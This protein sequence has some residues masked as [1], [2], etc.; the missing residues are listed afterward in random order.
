[1]ASKL[2]GGSPRAS[3]TRRS[4]LAMG[5]TGLLAGGAAVAITDVTSKTPADAATTSTTT[6]WV[7]VTSYG[8]DPTGA[9]DST[10]AFQSAIDS[11]TATTPSNSAGC[12][13]VYI[14]AGNYKIS[15]TVNCPTV[16][17]YFVG[18]G[19]WATTVLFYGSGDCFRIYDKS[20][21]GSRT[22]FGG[23]FVGI[24]IDG[25]NATGAAT[26]LHVG[27][28]LQYELDLTVQ[29]F[30]QAG[31]IGV[32]LDNNYYWT[33]QL[34]G[35]IYAQ[36]CAS[37][38]V[39]DWTSG[40]ATTSSGSFER[41]D[42]D[43]YINQDGGG[44]D[45]VV[46]RN[47]AFVTNGSLKIR[48]NFGYSSSTVTS[49]ALRL[50]GSQSVNGYPSASGIVASML[51]IGAECA[52]KA[53]TYVPQTIVFGASSNQIN[54][55]YGALNFGAAGTTFAASNNNKNIIN[56]VGQSNGDSTLPG[57]TSWVTYS[58]GFPTGITG[59]VSFRF[60]P[61]GNEVMVSW[62]LA[63]AS[64][65]KMA[66]NTTIVTAASMYSA[67]DNKLLPGNATGAGLSGNGYAAASMSPGGIFKYL[68]P[69]YT[70]TGGSSWW[71]GQ[72][73]YTLSVG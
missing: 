54:G 30:S 34:F 65:T 55:C 51:D 67:N 73:V 22:K 39:F 2:H 17:V 45:G 64:G 40:T 32:H 59:N 31:S 43:I 29:S 18:D 25:T 49:A 3:S 62:A 47:G 52:T 68:G 66:S 38:V 70:S 53:G 14:P 71:F 42:L 57:Q 12:G 10:S 69:A 28:L 16:P 35:R 6:D 27:D 13:V 58:S 50:T 33:E 36:K 48:G 61:T 24:T 19:A 5:A 56:F 44:F 63:I 37:H 7:N 11:F 23:G 21:Y 20:T 4:L 9:I 8:A 41:C 46:F 72:G 1:L 15:G 60:L 26:G